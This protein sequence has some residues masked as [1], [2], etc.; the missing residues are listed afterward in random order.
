MGFW[1]YFWRSKTSKSDQRQDPGLVQERMAQAAE[2]RSERKVEG[3]DEKA[4]RT[5][6]KRRRMGKSTTL[7]QSSSSGLRES[8]AT[9]SSAQPTMSSSGYTPADSITQAE[10][11]E[12]DVAAGERR[13]YQHNPKSS[14]S[15]E[16]E[17]FTAAGT[18]TL[19][20]KRGDR[21]PP[22]PRRKSSKRKAE[23]QARERELRAMSSPVTTS[24]RPISYSAASPL[25]RDTQKAPNRLRKHTDRYTSE[26]SLPIPESLSDLGTTSN[27]TSFKISGLDVLRPRPTVRHSTNPHQGALKS[28]KL[29]GNSVGLVIAEEDCSSRRRI[30][31]LADGLDARALRE[32]MERDQRRRERKRKIEHSKLEEKLKRTAENEKGQEARRKDQSKAEEQSKAAGPAIANTSSA[33]PH[34]RDE[35]KLIQSDPFSDDKMIAPELPVPPRLRPGSSIYTRNSQASLSPPNSPI[36]RAFDG[37]SMSQT[38]GLHREATPDIVDPTEPSQRASEQSNVQSGS[39]TSFFKRGGTRGKRSSVDY[40]RYMSGEFSNTSRDSVSRSQPQTSLVGAPRTFQ[41]SG[42]PQR[43]QS[44][45]REDLPELPLSPPDSRVHSPEAGTGPAIV[46]APFE[47]VDSDPNTSRLLANSLTSANLDQNPQSGQPMQPQANEPQTP[48]PVAALSTSLASV[49]SEAS[50]LSGKAAKRSSYQRDHPLRQSQSSLHPQLFESDVGEEVDVANDPYF[51]RLSPGEVERRRSSPN[52]ALRKASSTALNIGSDSDSEGEQPVPPMPDTSKERW[53]SGKGRQPTLIRQAAQ[54]RSKEGLLKEYQA[55]DAESGGVEDGA[56]DLESPDIEDPDLQASSS[57][58]L[59]AQSINFSAGH[60]RHI[61][62]GSAKLLEIR[63]SSIDS[64][65]QSLPRIERSSTPIR[66]TTLKMEE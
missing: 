14:T 45:F 3:G 22:V 24:K 66:S 51:S 33:P 46:P 52:S 27:Q 41:R 49:D 62:A 21:D 53:H 55:T 15:V 64:K 58:I 28:Q 65:R 13:G 56:S 17:H 60:I 9:P 39:W 44:K 30:E 23:E 63:R 32:L 18:P 47:Q 38:S 54:A 8:M 36:H 4:S 50:W 12:L 6:S 40:G 10:M 35:G 29:A 42:I 34:T 37:A 20:A 5:N 16:Q 57:P 31:D 11:K 2:G 43:T 19:H 61:S 1:S 25:R 26:I 48:P 7:S 59:R